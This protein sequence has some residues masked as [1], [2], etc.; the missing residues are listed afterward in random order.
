[1][2]DARRGEFDIVAVAAFDRFARSTRHLVLASA[3]LSRSHDFGRPNR[4][5]IRVGALS[6][7]RIIGND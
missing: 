2:A 5:M 4:G 7:D 6:D 1:M 3:R